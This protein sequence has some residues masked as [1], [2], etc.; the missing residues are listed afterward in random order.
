MV[1]Q[2]RDV[3]ALVDVKA[4]PRDLRRKRWGMHPKG[5][6]RLFRRPLGHTLADKDGRRGCE[7]TKPPPVSWKGKRGYWLEVPVLEKP[8]A[9]RGKG[10]PPIAPITPELLGP[11]SPAITG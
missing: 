3:M 4:H 7:K 8:R 5:F 9:V 11:H 6:K 2:N 1:K 10:S